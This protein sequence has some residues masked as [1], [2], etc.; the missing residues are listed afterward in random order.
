MSPVKKIVAESVEVSILE[1]PNRDDYFSI[2]DM[3]KAQDGELFVTDWLRNRNT[4]E[5]LGAWGS[6][7]NPIFNYG[8]FATIRN[9]AGLNNFKISVKEWVFGKYADSSEAGS[10]G[11]RMVGSIADF[12]NFSFHAVKNFTTAEGGAMSWNLPFGEEKVEVMQA[13]QRMPASST[14]ASRRSPTV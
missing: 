3:M 7:N 9:Q 12:S 8:E 13:G 2:T 14:A 6:M 5:Y 11:C 10:V 1:R 4:L